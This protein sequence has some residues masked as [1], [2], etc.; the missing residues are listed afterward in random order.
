MTTYTARSHRARRPGT[1]GP[2][3][4]IRGPR[5]R[6]LFA[7][8]LFGGSE[9]PPS[10]LFGVGGGSRRGLK[11]LFFMAY[12]TVWFQPGAPPGR[13]SGPIPVFGDSP[14]VWKPK[15]SG[16]RYPREGVWDPPVLDPRTPFLMAYLS[17][18]FGRFWGPGDPKIGFLTPQNRFLDPPNRSRVQ[19]E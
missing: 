17:I 13:G 4:K 11:T 14:R 18:R 2:G 10:S 6:I 15:V 16:A 8:D 7:P 3:D 19:N 1:G 9:T 12:L 5:P